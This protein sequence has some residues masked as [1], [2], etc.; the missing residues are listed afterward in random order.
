MHSKRMDS[1][2]PE[3]KG[4]SIRQAAKA[5][6]DDDGEVDKGDSRQAKLEPK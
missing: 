2:G 5:D 6:K 3:H 4:K 1:P